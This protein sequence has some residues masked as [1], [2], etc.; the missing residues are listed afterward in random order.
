MFYRHGRDTYEYKYFLVTDLDPSLRLEMPSLGSSE[1]KTWIM[2]R[3][4]AVVK[5]D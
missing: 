3:L 1:W 5:D 2:K 4:I